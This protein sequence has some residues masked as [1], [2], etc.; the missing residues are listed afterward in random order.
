MTIF[1]GQLT[2]ADHALSYPSLHG[3]GNALGCVFHP[4]AVW[5]A[6]IMAMS[7]ASRRTWFE[8]TAAHLP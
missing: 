6:S 3:E 5:A 7:A 4:D 8:S 1:M 2:S